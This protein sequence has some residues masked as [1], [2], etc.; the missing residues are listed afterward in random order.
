M[1]NLGR[2]LWAGLMVV[3]AATTTASP[4]QALNDDAVAEILEVLRNRGLLD[5]SEYERLASKHELQRGLAQ[6]DVAADKGG[7][8]SGFDWSGDLR[9]RYEGARYE[10]N[11][12]GNKPDSRNRFRYRLRFGFTK[13]INDWLSVGMRIA[14]G[15]C[16]GGDDPGGCEGGTPR[17]TNRSFG[18]GGDFDLDPLWIDR[19]YA[20]IRLPEG[21][22]GLENSLVVGKMGNPFRWSEMPDLVVWDADT[23]VEGFA[24][25]TGVSPSEGTRLFSRVGYLI[26]DQNSSNADPHVTA[27]QFGGTT[28]LSDA[29]SLGLRGSGYFWHS[30]GADD[31][32]FKTRA[33]SFG[34]LPGAFDDGAEIAELVG[35]VKF[36]TVPEWPAKL[37]GM[38][39]KNFSAK[40]GLAPVSSDPAAGLAPAGKDDT[41]WGAGVEFGSATKIVKLGVGYYE[42]EANSVI[43]SMTDSNLFDGETNRKGWVFTG[44]RNL[45]NAVAVRAALYK[46]KW[47]DDSPAYFNSFDEADRYRFQTDLVINY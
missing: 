42:V 32:A 43:A 21:P 40:S 23:S 33:E 10:D 30:L 44:S 38:Y 24:L 17:S 27:V 22:A 2:F 11:P 31:G 20:A 34:N 35:F 7:I 19:A 14:S 25:K 13:P 26:S 41:A 3:V 18:T 1:K 39:A 29:L 28:I 5:Q 45:T 16:I 37:Y 12:D 46:S 4:A 9:L 47:I 6:A 36:A 8:L 15:D